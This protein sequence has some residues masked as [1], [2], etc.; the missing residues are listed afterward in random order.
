MKSKSLLLSRC[1]EGGDW[2][3]SRIA[4]EE[5]LEKVAPLIDLELTASVR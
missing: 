3:E 2:P 1:T 4:F 5:L